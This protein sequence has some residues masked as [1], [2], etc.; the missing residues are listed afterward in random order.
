MPLRYL[1][2]N[3]YRRLS[4]KFYGAF[5]SIKKGLFFLEKKTVLLLRKPKIPCLYAGLCPFATF[6][7]KANLSN[8]PQ[9]MLFI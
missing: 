7:T 3:K 8:L 5:D 9:Q 4:K 2:Q 1:L 6:S